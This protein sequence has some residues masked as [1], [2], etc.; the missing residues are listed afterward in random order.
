MAPITKKTISIHIAGWILFLAFPLVFIASGSQNPT[1]SK[2]FLNPSYWVFLFLFVIAFY[3]H[4]YFLIPRLLFQ[5]KYIVYISSLII[6]LTAVVYLKP[7]DHLLSSV[8]SDRRTEMTE[9]PFDRQVAPPRGEPPARPPGRDFPPQG[10]RSGIRFDIISVFLFLVLVLVGISINYVQRLRHTQQLAAKAEADRIHA[11]LSFLKAQINP[12]FLFNTLNNIY[13]LA[14]SGSNQTAESVMKLSNIM[15]YVTDEVQEDFVSLENEISCIT[16]YID[17]QRLRL[18]QKVTIDFR[19]S[20][21]P[22][23]KKIAPLVLIPFIE[24]VFKY[25]VSNHDVSLLK[26]LIGTEGN[27]ITMETENKLFPDQIPRERTGIGIKITE[28]RLSQI[29]PGQY[30]L[31]VN[32]E[33]G[34]FRLYLKINLT[35]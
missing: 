14:V 26:I 30:R 5:K 12:H 16:D 31:Q 15:R 17:L 6:I 9:R 35:E 29:Y 23:D 1:L 32:R 10:K 25:G 3:F 33:D 22:A 19:V 20:G 28:T 13:Y 8:Q 2:F 27:T 18:G 4:T 11:E 7:F 34:L 24:N 21:D